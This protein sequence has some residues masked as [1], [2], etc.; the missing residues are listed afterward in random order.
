MN[1]C[2]ETEIVLGPEEFVRKFVN[3]TTEVQVMLNDFLKTVRFWV[4]D[5]TPTVCVPHSGFFVRLR[6]NLYA[7]SVEIVPM[8][9]KSG[10]CRTKSEIYLTTTHPTCLK[11]ATERDEI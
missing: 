8:G 7:A 2:P 4:I 3:G 11:L 6:A 1:I 10:E 9:V 5:N